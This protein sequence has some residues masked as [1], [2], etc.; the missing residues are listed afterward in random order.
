MIKFLTL[1]M[2]ELLTVDVSAYLLTFSVYFFA[3][4]VGI[5]VVCSLEFDVE[6]SLQRVIFHKIAEIDAPF[7]VSPPNFNFARAP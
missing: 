5:A 2:P 4:L 6:T 3:L 7:F 1:D